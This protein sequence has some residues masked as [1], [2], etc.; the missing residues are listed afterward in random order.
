MVFGRDAII[1]IQ[2]T[3]NG[4][5][6]KKLIKQNNKRENSKQSTHLYQVGEATL[7]KQD[8]HTKFG[9]DLT[10]VISQSQMYVTTELC[11][12]AWNCRR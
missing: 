7:I 12:S 1:T 8:Q 5:R 2:F 3:T 4:K 6:S 10:A 9:T 11:A